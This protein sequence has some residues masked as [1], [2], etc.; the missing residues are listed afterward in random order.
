MGDIAILTVRLNGKDFFKVADRSQF[1][2]I[3]IV[4]RP[5]LW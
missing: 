2:F 5:G 4:A 3:R 1:L